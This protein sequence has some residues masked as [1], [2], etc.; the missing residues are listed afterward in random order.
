MPRLSRYTLGARIDSLFLDTIALLLQAGYSGR[1]EKAAVVARACLT[2]DTLKYFLQIAW[3]VRALDSNAY[4][5]IAT[6]L[7]EVGR[8]LGGWKK[9]IQTTPPLP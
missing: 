4:A 8:M 1:E 2:L 5:R 7:A 6:P 3:E 9:Q